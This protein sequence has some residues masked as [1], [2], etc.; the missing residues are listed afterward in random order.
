M[1]TSTGGQPQARRAGRRALPADI[2]QGL[3]AAGLNLLGCL[4]RPRYDALVPEAWRA[5]R[6]L[7]VARSVL[8]VASGGRALFAAFRRSP[9]AQREPDPLDAFTRRVV[10]AAAEQLGGPWRALFAHER[11]GGVF[12]DFV[13]LGRAAGL[14]EPS[15]LGL[16]LHPVYGPWLSIR[17]LILTPRQRPET[18]PLADFAPCRGCP[19][20]C[21]AA[22]PGGAVAPAGFDVTACVAT[23]RR[24]PACGSR[25]AARRACVVGPQHAYTAQAEALHMRALNRAC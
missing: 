3:R 20:P 15:R 6:L 18:P 10:E 9:E 11:R 5:E 19:A 8:V 1:G 13:A 21:G 4:S 22:C 17:A 23:R 2:P 14:G 7:P 12:A 24:E 16:L 25:C